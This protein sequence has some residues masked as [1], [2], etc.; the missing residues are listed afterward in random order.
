MARD[1]RGCPW[2]PCRH[3]ATDWC[4]IGA[5]LR[6]TPANTHTVDS[7]PKFELLGS[8]AIRVQRC[9]IRDGLLISGSEVRV[10][11]GSPRP[12]RVDPPQTGCYDAGSEGPPMAKIVRIFGKDS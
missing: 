10:L 6:C 2:R 11:H 1:V 4:P 7:R 3:E 12:P 8:W 5:K 9:L